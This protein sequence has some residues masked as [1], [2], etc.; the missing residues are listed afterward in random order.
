MAQHI[1]IQ[2]EDIPELI[3]KIENNPYL[4]TFLVERNAWDKT[5]ID[6]DVRVTKLSDDYVEQKNLI[7]IK[8]DVP[9]LS[10]YMKNEEWLEEPFLNSADLEIHLNPDFTINK[11]FIVL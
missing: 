8:V 11:I 2:N 3:K 10:E 7:P 6:T 9:L 4:I 1:P 5:T